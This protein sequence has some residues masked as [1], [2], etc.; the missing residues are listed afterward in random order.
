MT[1]YTFVTY[2]KRSMMQ[3]K[4]SIQEKKK[5]IYTKPPQP[6]VKIDLQMIGNL[7]LNSFFTLSHFLS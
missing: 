6:C 1:F 2:Y 7:K 4:G 3:Y 5:K